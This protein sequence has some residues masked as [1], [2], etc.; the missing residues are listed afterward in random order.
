MEICDQFLKDIMDVNPTLNDFFSKEEYKKKRHIQPNIYSEDY[1]KKMNDIDHKYLKILEKKKDENVYDQLLLKDIKSSI[2]FEEN[3]KIY[4]YLPIDTDNI[5]IDYVSEA[6]GNGYFKFNEK[7]DYDDFIGRLKTIPKITDEII[8]K[9]RDGMKNK[10]TLYSKTVDQ[11]IDIIQK[12]LKN[13]Q[14]LNKKK[15]KHQKR[16]NEMIE[17]YL[18]ENLKKLFNFL[19]NEYYEHTSSKFGLHSFKEGKKYYRRLV[20]DSLFDGLTPENIHNQGLKELKLLLKEKKK[21]ERKMKL[22]D[23]DD[24]FKNNPDFYYKNKKDVIDD[25]KTIRERLYNEI[26]PKVF[27]GKF[28][29]SDMYDIKSVPIEDKNYTAYY[30]RPP[31][32]KSSKGTFYINTIN[33]ENINKHEL[34]VLSLHEG[35]PGHHYELTYHMENDKNKPDYFKLVGYDSYSEG[36][37]LYSEKL[38]NYQND[39]EY[40]FRIQY[41]I[42]RTIRLIIDTAIHYFGWEYDKCFDF[43]RKHLP[44]SDDYIKKE[45]LRY[46]NMPC[47]ALTY[48]IGEKVMLYL[49]KTCMMDGYNLKDFHKKV[50]ELG[51]C[52]LD[53]LMKQFNVSL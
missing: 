34:Y 16:L 10:V 41:D 30:R 2:H 53:I 40:Y 4:I 46:I 3:Y 52:H 36:W 49:R 42:H 22:K 12:I 23:I 44:F 20:K 21:L 14:Y 8:S 39:H 43:M 6:N 29:K 50:M 31:L 47:Q 13:K 17:K 32:D 45:I 7:K 9:M 35:I 19:V 33:P 27:H 48:K 25:L 26:Y 5:L 37:G 24:Y 1:Y 28:K 18:G 11:M 38:G 51:P 15:S